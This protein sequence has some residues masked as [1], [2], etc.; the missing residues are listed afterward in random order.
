MQVPY[1]FVKTLDT[2]IGCFL[3]ELGDNLLILTSF[4]GK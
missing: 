2:Y 1:A 4:K 3:M